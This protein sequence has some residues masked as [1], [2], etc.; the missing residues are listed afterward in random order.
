M[1][2]LPVRNFSVSLD[3]YAAGPHQDIDHPLGVGGMHLH[4]RLFATRSFAETIGREDGSQG[5]E[6]VEQI[7]SRGLDPTPDR[8]GCQ[9]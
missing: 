8:L 7:L 4:E 6:R 1:P 2:R 5:L 3:G 9:G